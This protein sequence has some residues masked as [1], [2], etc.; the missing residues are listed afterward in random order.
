V[1]DLFDDVLTIDYSPKLDR[2]IINSPRG[3]GE[4]LKEQCP[5]S[6]FRWNKDLNAWTAAAHHDQVKELSA[7][8]LIWTPQ[9]RE[10]A[11]SAQERAARAYE[12]SKLKEGSLVLPGFGVEPYPFQKAGIE[13]ALERKRVIIGDEM[14]LG[15]T[16]QALGTI[17]GA[18][19]YPALI[20]TP[21]SLKYN[22]GETEIPRA[23]KG[24]RVVIADK[25][26]PELLLRM[27]DLIVTNY[28]QLV[29]IKSFKDNFTGKT[30]KTSWHDEKKE[31]VILSDLALILQR[32]GL[33]SIVLDEAHYIKNPSAARSKAVMEMR[34]GVPIRLP[35]TG[36][37]FLN[38][39]SDFSMLIKFLDRLDEF[40]GWWHF[41]T[42]W[43]GLASGDYGWE[44]TGKDTTPLNRKMRE[45]CYIRRQKQDVLTE[46]PD[47]TRS[48]VLLEIDNREE[49]RK[50]KKE[51]VE[52][53]RDRVLKDEKFL[54][55]IKHLPPLEQQLAIRERQEEKAVK[56]E[57]GER[58]VRIQALKNITARG[59]LKAAFE[60][61]DNF[62]ASGE[63]LVLFA[64][65]KEILN[66]ILKKYPNAAKILSELSDRERHAE[67]QR[68]QTDPKCNLMVLA[69]GTSATNS[70]GGVGWTLTASSNVAFL[71]LGWNNALHDQCEDRC[72]RI[73][74]VCKVTAWYLLGR[75][76]YDL[77]IASLIESKRGRSKQV[78]DGD[79]ARIEQGIL[80]ELFERIA[81]ETDDEEEE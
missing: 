7:L 18:N 25:K 15:K 4:K 1:F 52:W 81:H 41:M 39:E 22:W 5:G 50:A 43:C 51:L 20:V 3:T 12:Q 24:R 56:A 73:G 6:G 14:G 61:I 63:K 80:D 75:K 33:K 66:A 36:T 78:T 49:Y 55:S 42:H 8:E 32:L 35:L 10:H 28:E 44:S 68:F 19:A 54:D 64:T 48:T 47:K 23:I 9:A 76:T 46:L 11:D 53:V 13:Y 67:C 72:H 79:E 70:P 59:K 27:S 30:F 57:K 38:N 74:Q 26:T 34:H 65:H 45:T 77:E 29:G 60:W 62:L 16:I 69:M 31:K 37:P 2:F 40:G 21:A 71:E 58:M 17:Y